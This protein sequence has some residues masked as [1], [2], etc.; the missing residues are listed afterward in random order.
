MEKK[1]PVESTKPSWWEIVGCALAFA[2]FFAFIWTICTVFVFAFE[3]TTGVDLYT[4][5]LVRVIG[6]YCD[7]LPYWPSFYIQMVLAV[8]IGSVCLF[9]IGLIVE[10]MSAARGFVKAFLKC[11]DKSD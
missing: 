7:L 11:K 1:D 6:S 3:A 8:L 10:I 9:V 2:L 4:L 5:P